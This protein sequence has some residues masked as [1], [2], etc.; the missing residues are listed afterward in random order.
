M[1]GLPV[2]IAGATGRMGSLVARAVEAAPELSLVARPGRGA[3]EL[4]WNGA[5][6]LGDFT[7][8]DGTARLADLAAERGVGLVVGTTGLDEAARAA[9]ER[10]ARKVAVL[11]APN[12]SLGVAALARALKAALAALPGYDVEIVERH[13]AAKADSPSGTALALAQIVQD[14]RPGAVI[15]PGREGRTGPRP[16]SEIGIHSL[17]GGAWVGE[18]A[19]VLAGPFETVE[20]SHVA[21]D[22][23][24]FAYGA[25][26]A[27]RF[28]AGA[29]PGTY[30]L[31]DALESPGA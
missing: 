28:V 27:L 20:L 29:P 12:L 4:G 9:L 24:A 8:P 30:T 11:V 1:S 6:A 25:L 23:A 19:V 26:A 2:A 17:R 18:H 16:G 22:R 14:A 31:E 13:H 21:H 3:L 5:Q 15:R 10:A 7:A